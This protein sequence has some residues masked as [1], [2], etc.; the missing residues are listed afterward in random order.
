MSNDRIRMAVQKSGRLTEK[1]F[2]LL[3]RCGLRFNSSKGA[4]LA[5]CE[6]F[7]LDLLMLR[8]DDIPEYVGEG[9][10][11]LGIVGEN[12]LREKSLKD[13]FE[14]NTLAHLGFGRCR[15]SLAVPISAE[16]LGFNWF[17]NKRI[18]TS[19]PL[20]LQKFLDQNKIKGSVIE[21]SGS[22]EVAPTLGVAEAICDLVSTGSTLKSNGLKE[23]EVL[24][25]SE[26]VLIQSPIELNIE[27]CEAIG[28]LL[29]RIE[30]L[31]KADSHKYVM[32]NAPRSSLTSLKKILPGMEHPSIMSL[33]GDEDKVAVHAVC[34]EEVFWSTIEKLKAA[35]ASS[36]LV[37]PIEKIM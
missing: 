11:E 7:P 10:C 12:V 18:A 31:Q 33:E 32:M 20:L 9:T 19:Y 8:D 28:R 34:R 1:T 37:L 21:L 29:I 25:E 14:C 36:I 26:S 15:L 24:L 23:V 5:Q 27:K 30:G 16:Y 35:G 6:N 4:L 3:S 13:E 22:V 17:Q 2:D